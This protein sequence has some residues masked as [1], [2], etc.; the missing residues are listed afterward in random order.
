MIP[1]RWPVVVDALLEHLEEHPELTGRVFDGQPVTGDYIAAGVFV[2]VVL[3][4]GTTGDAG[5]I[6]QTVHELGGQP[7][8]DEDGMVRCQVAVQRGDTDLHAAR[9]MCFALLGAAES[10]IRT[11]PDLDVDGLLWIGSTTAAP[12]QGQTEAGARCEVEWRVTYRALI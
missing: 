3:D 11:H 8:R 12:R 9:A 2:G 7:P 10:V 4:E 6:S 5:T 1:T